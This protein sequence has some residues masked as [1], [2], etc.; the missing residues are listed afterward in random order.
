MD[1]PLDGAAAPLEVKRSLHGGQS[2][3]QSV[4]KTADLRR[5]FRAAGPIQPRREFRRLTALDHLDE[6]PSP[7]GAGSRL[8]TRFQKRLEES[9]L[10]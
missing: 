8:R 7:L 1:V 2:R 10:L 5:S 4:D 6:L 3:P 9:A